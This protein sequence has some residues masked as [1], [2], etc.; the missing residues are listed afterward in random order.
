[1]EKVCCERPFFLEPV[2]VTDAQVFQA[3]VKVA[4]FGVGN[5]VEDACDLVVFR[6]CPAEGDR[7]P[8]QKMAAQIFR[9]RKW[10]SVSPLW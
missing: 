8:E 6:N 3:F 1:M 4:D 7:F 2:A 5:M 10:E 9:I